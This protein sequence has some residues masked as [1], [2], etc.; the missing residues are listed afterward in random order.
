MKIIIGIAH[1][2]LLVWL[3]VIVNKIHIY[4]NMV[5]LPIC[6]S[7]HKPQ[8]ILVTYYCLC[9]VYMYIVYSIV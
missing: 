2:I 7:I 4:Y 6:S 3:C 9:T 1:E 5:H 8:S